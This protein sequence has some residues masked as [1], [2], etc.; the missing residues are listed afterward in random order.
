VNE[1]GNRF[2]QVIQPLENPET[3]AQQWM[4]MHI[5]PDLGRL[6]TSFAE[7]LAAHPDLPVDKTDREILKAG[8]DAT[9]GQLIRVF[10]LWHRAMKLDLKD[11]AATLQASEQQL[12]DILQLVA[13]A[14]DEGS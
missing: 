10:E 7:E 9:N 11:W 5:T 12:R 4:A 1:V 3:D 14:R 2:H 13:D 6:L 8:A